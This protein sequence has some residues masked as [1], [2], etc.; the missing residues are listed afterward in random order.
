MSTIPDRLSAALADRYRIERELGQGGMATVYLAQDLK[1]DRK[2][3]IKV[4]RPELAAVI[5]ATELAARLPRGTVGVALH[6]DGKTMVVRGEASGAR[7]GRL[8]KLQLG[9]D[10]APVPLFAVAGGESSPAFSPDGRWLAYVSDESGR[11][12]VYVRPFPD[13]D[14]RKIQVSLD[15]GAA[16]RWNP[17]GEEL[18]YLSAAGDMM[19]AR[20]ATTPTLNVTGVTRLFT[21]QG[22]QGGGTRASVSGALNT[23]L[24]SLLYEVGRDS[25]FLMLD[26]VAAP[27]NASDERLVVVQNIGAELAKRLPQ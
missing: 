22:F 5:G 7:R 3:A 23:G 11:A 2:V 14:T 27:A 4:L 25:R 18:F 16:P 17:D 6:P 12:E 19:A 21:P 10:S 24:S 26:I 15:G 9:T 8:F 13:L 1:H 20:M